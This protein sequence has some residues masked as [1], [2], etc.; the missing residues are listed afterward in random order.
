MFVPPGRTNSGF[1]DHD[2][3]AILVNKVLKTFDILI[4][5]IV[6]VHTIKWGKSY[7]IDNMIGFPSGCEFKTNYSALITVSHICNNGER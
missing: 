1:T 3:S 7:T 6:Y 5:A 2:S 4:P